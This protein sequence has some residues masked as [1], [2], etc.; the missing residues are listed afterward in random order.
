[1]KEKIVMIKKTENWFFE[2]IKKKKKKLAN[3]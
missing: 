1:M 2:K 3:L